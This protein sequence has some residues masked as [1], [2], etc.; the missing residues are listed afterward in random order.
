MHSTKED[1]TLEFHKLGKMITRVYP[2][3]IISFQHHARSDYYAIMGMP[4]QPWLFDIP[5]I[6]EDDHMAIVN[7]F[8]DHPPLQ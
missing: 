3:V 6:F 4:Y 7:K 5:L 2:G 1:K 8:N